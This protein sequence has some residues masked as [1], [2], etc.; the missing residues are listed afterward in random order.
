MND[1][2]IIVSTHSDSFQLQP[3]Q[4]T[5]NNRPAILQWMNTETLN[6]PECIRRL[7]QNGRFVRENMLCTSNRRNT[8]VCRGDSG[9]PLQTQ[10]LTEVLIG[11]VSWRIGCASGFPDVYTRIHPHLQFIRRNIQV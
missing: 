2:A 1:R 4:P 3:G 10:G 9:S 11:I 7:A 5:P 8:G 6:R